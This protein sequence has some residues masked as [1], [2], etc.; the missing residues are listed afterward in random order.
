MNR[1]VFLL[2]VHFSLVLAYIHIVN[3]RTLLTNKTVLCVGIVLI[4]RDITFINLASTHIIVSREDKLHV[5][6][7]SHRLLIIL[8]CTPYILKSDGNE[9]KEKINKWF[10][11]AVLRIPL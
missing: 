10:N 6:N 7:S 8:F 3:E 11:N 9:Q 1:F 2:R 4:L 5:Q